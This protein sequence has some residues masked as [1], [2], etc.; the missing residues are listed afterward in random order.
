MILTQEPPRC[1]DPIQARPAALA[2]PVTRHECDG[3]EDSMR[4]LSPWPT[5]DARRRQR[6]SLSA[7][8]SH[9]VPARVRSRPFAGEEPAPVDPGQQRSR[10]G[11]AQ[12]CPAP[13]PAPA[14]SRSPLAC[15]PLAGPEWSHG[16]SQSGITPTVTVSHLRL[17]VMVRFQV[18]RDCCTRCLHLADSETVTPARPGD[19]PPA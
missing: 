10:R 4:K 3:G 6:A 14:S 11:A 12:G 17:C 19:G 2:A 13:G 8:G 5:S 15:D 16:G 7:N 1:S 9:S 18:H